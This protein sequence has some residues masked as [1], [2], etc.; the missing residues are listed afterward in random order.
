[1][2]PD[3]PS[4]IIRNA[5]YVTS[6]VCIQPLKSSPDEMWSYPVGCDPHSLA[7][8]RPHSKSFPDRGHVNIIS[9]SNTWLLTSTHSFGITLR[10]SSILAPQ[11][12]NIPQSIHIPSLRI[13]RT[14]IVVWSGFRKSKWCLTIRSRS[15]QTTTIYFIQYNTS[16]IYP[17]INNSHR[18]PYSQIARIIIARSSISTFTILPNTVRSNCVIIIAQCPIYNLYYHWTT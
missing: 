8:T 7:S 14:Q 16:N 12:H 5:E 10:N 2:C 11:I 1:M 6:T 13:Q 9:P 3:R 18:T 4:S 17:K 15:L